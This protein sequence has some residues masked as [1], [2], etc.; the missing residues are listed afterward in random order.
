[1]AFPHAMAIEIDQT[2][3]AAV[4]VPGGVDFGMARHPPPDLIFCMFGSP[5]HPWEHV[6]LLARL[7]RLVRSEEARARLRAT[8]DAAD[9]YARLVQEDRS[10]G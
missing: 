1:V 3:V 2:L 4:Y 10:Q 5:Q 7:A 9:L 8:T 6:R